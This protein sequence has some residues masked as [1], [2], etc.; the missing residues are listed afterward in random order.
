MYSVFAHI[1]I[2]D[3]HIADFLDLI[4]QYAGE[5]LSAEPGTLRYDVVQDQTNPAHFI[6]HET[7]ADEAAF[8]THMQGPIGQRYLAQVVPLM[9]SP[10]DSSVFLGMG[11]NVTPAQS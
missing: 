1:T 5:W 10:L 9:S 4:R 11:T 3:Q 8:A 2:H 6:F 7:Y